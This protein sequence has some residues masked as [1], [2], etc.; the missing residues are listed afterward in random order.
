M[1]CLSNCQICCPTELFT[2]RYAV[3]TVVLTKIQVLWGV[4]P[5][6]LVNRHRR[7]GGACCL[8]LQVPANPRTVTRW[9]FFTL[10]NLW[11]F[12]DARYFRSRLCFRLQERAAPNLLDPSDTASCWLVVRTWTKSFNSD[13]I[14][15][16]GFGRWF[17]GYWFW[18][19]CYHEI[20]VC[21]LGVSK[22]KSCRYQST[23][24]V[25]E[26]CCWG[27]CLWEYRP[28]VY[29]VVFLQPRNALTKVMYSLSH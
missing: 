19:T 29:L 25:M 7:F 20:K 6:R 13:D 15:L 28:K 21:A 12:N 24:C 10:S 18:E 14:C 17:L 5:C 26:I 11:I 8:L 9:H 27:H 1:S 3:L 22:Y 16:Y 23:F 4:T 2:Q